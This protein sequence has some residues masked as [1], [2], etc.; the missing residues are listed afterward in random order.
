VTL[1]GKKNHYGIKLLRGY[2]VSINLK[3]NRIC[4][5]DGRDPFTREQ[6]TEE[7]FVTQIP[8]ERIV[9]SGRRYLS[10][11]AI[12]PLTDLAR[13]EAVEFVYN[14]PRYLQAVC[15]RIALESFLTPS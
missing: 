4:L 10:T 9:I 1:K 15:V 13:Y 14:Q 12:K 2:G 8:Y 11:D 6:A 7:W 5:K 3:D